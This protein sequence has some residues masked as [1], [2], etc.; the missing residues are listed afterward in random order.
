VIRVLLGRDREQNPR[1]VGL[2]SHYR[3]ESFFCL[4]GKD[5][6]HEKGGVEGEIGR[7]RRTHLMTPMPKVASL[8]A[9]NEVMA[10]ADAADN[11]RHIGVRRETVGAAAAREQPLLRALPDKAFDPS[12]TLSCRVDTK[13]RV[14]VRQS[15]YSAPAHLAG[16]RVTV[17][18]GADSVRVVADGKTVAVHVRSLH[19]GTEDLVLDHYLEVLTRKP[20]ALAGSTALVAARACGALTQTH[21]RFWDAARRSLGNGAGTRVLIAVLLLHRALPAEAVTA[22]MVAALTSGRFDADL[23]AVEARRQVDAGRP[24]AQV[25]ALASVPGQVRALPILHGYD[26]LLTAVSA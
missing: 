15:Y 6:A 25:T 19:K 2:R 9:L 22:A 24:V 7:F 14:C 26:E 17:L 16:R 13:A 20:G 21:Q 10:A 18:L 3:F 11:G 5:G 4:P 23:V 8:A 12:L 1:F